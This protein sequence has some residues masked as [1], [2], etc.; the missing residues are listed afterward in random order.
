MPRLGFRVRRW[1]SLAKV[2][3]FVL[4]V[5]LAWPLGFGWA[6]PACWVTL[7]SETR[8]DRVVL[9]HGATLSLSFVNSI[10]DQLET[11]IFRLDRQCRLV[12]TQLA[13]SG[14]GAADYGSDYLWDIGPISSLGVNPASDEF[15]ARP[16]GR[17]YDELVIRAD[18]IGQFQ[19]EAGG[20]RWRLDAWAGDG[21]RVK[22]QTGSLPAILAPLIIFFD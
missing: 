19:L 9:R 10:Y 11:D 8:N 3:G 17:T 14:G 20:R 16:S 22:I 18:A 7:S 6:E 1:R 2:V 21:A 15:T 5:V 4:T 13:F 12:L